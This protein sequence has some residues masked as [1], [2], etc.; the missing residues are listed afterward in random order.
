M[1]SSGSDRALAVMVL[2]GSA[3]LVPQNTS[4]SLLGS[5]FG[6]RKVLVIEGSMT[7]RTGWTPKHRVVD[8]EVMARSSVNWNRHACIARKKRAS[9]QAVNYSG[10]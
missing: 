3:F 7:G 9:A 1:M 10:H 8:S 5:G 4:V 6:V 2:N